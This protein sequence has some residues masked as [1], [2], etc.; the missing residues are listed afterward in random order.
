MSG[1]TKGERGGK[2]GCISE[3]SASGS[4]PPQ[5]GAPLA[6]VSPWGKMQVS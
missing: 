6:S 3:C 5:N 1:K 2:S 4:A